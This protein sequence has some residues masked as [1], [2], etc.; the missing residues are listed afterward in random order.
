[1]RLGEEANVYEHTR[2]AQ[3]LNVEIFEDFLECNLEKEIFAPQPQSDNRWNETYYHFEGSLTKH[4]SKNFLPLFDE[5]FMPALERLPQN[6]SKTP[7]AQNKKRKEIRGLLNITKP[8]NEYF[9]GP[10]INYVHGFSCNKKQDKYKRNMLT[11]F[12]VKYD[13]ENIFYPKDLLAIMILTMHKIWYEI[14]NPRAP[15]KTLAPVV[16][17]AEPKIVPLSPSVDEVKP[18][19]Q[20]PAIIAPAPTPKK[21]K[22]KT[23]TR[24]FSS[25]H[26]SLPHFKK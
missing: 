26:F 5:T 1:M 20:A 18:E 3:C 23:L 6:L 24:F 9:I 17:I 15:A 13:A 22:K 2:D 11:F 21:K 8:E 19:E 12:E 14:G 16:A 4:L 10:W 25:A 7:F